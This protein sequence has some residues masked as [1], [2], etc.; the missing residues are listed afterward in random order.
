[1][2]M[3]MKPEAPLVSII[4]PVYNVAIYLHQCVSSVLKQTY[5][6]IEVILVNDGST[7]GGCI[8]C[9]SFTKKDNRV[10]VIHQENKGLVSARKLGL[11]AANGDYIFN[12]DGDDWLDQECIKTLI[13]HAVLYDVD[14]VISGYYR[15]FVGLEVP[16]PPRVAPGFYNRRDIVNDIFPKMIFDTNENAHG[17]STFS[18]GKLFKRNLIMKHQC[19]VP[20]DITLGED[21]LVTYPCI[22]DAKSLIVL[23]DPLYFYRQ[24]AKSMLKSTSSSKNEVARVHRMCDFL[25]NK[26]KSTAFDFNSQIALYKLTLLAIRTGALFNRKEPPSGIFPKHLDFNAQKI[27]LYSS[28][29][30]GQQMWQRFKDQELNFCGWFDEDHFESKLWGVDVSPIGELPK[31][32]PDV[33]IVASF[34]KQIFNEIKNRILLIFTKCEVIQPLIPEDSTSITARI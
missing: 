12:L 14:V 1:M 25:Q 24:R 16:I 22:A 33:V 11:K 27:A 7:D 32:A 31:I 19:D 17:I 20:D 30:F 6:N 4:V 2:R 28:G 15:E 29:S 13:D 8:L 34:D 9:E 26:M 3:R 5:R 18:W 23:N 21:S 10:R